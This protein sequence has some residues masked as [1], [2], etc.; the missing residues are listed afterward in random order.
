MNLLPAQA[1]AIDKLQAVKVGALFMEPGTGKTRAAYELV[2]SV[3]GVDYVLYLAPFQGIN[4]D[5]YKESI[6]AE[7]KRCGGF[8]MEH[9]FIGVESLSNSDRIYLDIRAKLESASNP[10]I[11]MDESLKIKN[12]DAIRTRRTLDFSNLAEYKLI[13]NGTPL[14]RDLLDLYT[15]MNF[16]SPKILSMGLAEFKNTFCEYVNIK[17]TLG[18]RR[19]EKEFIVAYHNVDYLYQLIS[20]F[21]FESQLSL[22][23]G[24]QYHDISYRLTSEEKVDHDLLKEKYL[25]D[26]HMEF[27]NNNIFLEITAKLRHNYTLSPEKFAI[28]ERLIQKHGAKQVLIYAFFIEAQEALKN[29][30]PEARIMSIG[31]HTFS[32]NL[33]AYSVM[34]FWD[35]TWDFAQRDQIIPRIVRDGKRYYKTSSKQ[36]Q[37]SK[38]VRDLC[39]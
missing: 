16:L 28:I 19:L 33:Q 15:Q 30:F 22:S 5:N 6:P 37:S 18:H 29:E 31:K 9:D 4:T 13:L 36:Y 20:P 12:G 14:S 23:I 26:E 21:V 10:F 35:K 11:I 27:R 39:K 7:I 24:V 17:K 25:D 34:I 8:S 3:K 2:R 32:L 38:V 1:N